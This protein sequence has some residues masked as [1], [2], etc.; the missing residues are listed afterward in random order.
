MFE[1]AGGP[2]GL[3]GVVKG[4]VRTCEEEEARGDLGSPRAEVLSL[5]EEGASDMAG[6]S[7]D[8]LLLWRSRE[9]RVKPATT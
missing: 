2:P 5:G 6:G 4:G 8:G 7:T 9:E 3:N 1:D